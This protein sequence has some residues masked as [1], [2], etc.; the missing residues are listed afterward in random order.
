MHAKKKKDRLEPWKCGNRFACNKSV[1]KENR[2]HSSATITTGPR[3]SWRR[4]LWGERYTM[5]WGLIRSTHL[6]PKVGQFGIGWGVIF[7]RTYILIINWIQLFCFYI[8]KFI[9]LIGK[10]Y[11]VQLFASVC[12]WSICWIWTTLGVHV[13][14]SLSLIMHCCGAVFPSKERHI[15]LVKRGHPQMSHR[16]VPPCWEGDKPTQIYVCHH[17]ARVVCLLGRA[18]GPFFAWNVVVC[19]INNLSTTSIASRHRST[20]SIRRSALV[21]Q[22]CGESWTRLQRNVDDLVD[23][24]F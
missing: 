12:L 19:A 9:E 1:T 18:G 17:R 20:K 10:F 5:P 2:L 6:S 24:N 13:T 4:E 16:N 7:V 15:A 3:E 14:W 22:P 8:N 11:S 21:T 23:L